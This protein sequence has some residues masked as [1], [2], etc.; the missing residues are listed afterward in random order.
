MPLDAANRRA[1][2]CVVN[3]SAALFPDLRPT[4]SVELQ[5]YNERRKVRSAA[6]WLF[7]SW[8]KLLIT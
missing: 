6:A 4:D 8:L 2:E 7:E 5:H 1:A 3:L